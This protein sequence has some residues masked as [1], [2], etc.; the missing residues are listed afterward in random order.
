M[1]SFITSLYK[2]GDYLVK[3]C[4]RT[5]K[6][7][8][9]LKRLGC[10]AEFVIIANEP[11]KKERV[12][13]DRLAKNS[14]FHIYEVQRETLYASWNRG[15]NL[16]RGNVLGFW[17]VDDSRSAASIIEAKKIFSEPV[18]LVYF[19][20]SII[21][22]F[23]IFGF[24]LPVKFRKIKPPEFEPREFSRSMLCGPFFMFTK[25]FYNQVGPFDEQ[26]KV[27]ADFDWCIRAAKASGKFVLA[28]SLGGVFRVDGAGLSAG[29][30]NIRTMEN[31]VIYT[32]HKIFDKLIK[33]DG[34]FGEEYM[35]DKIFGNNKTIDYK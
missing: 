21:W 5:Q 2:S 30:N 28:D 19:P 18:D 35:A 9:R 11:D 16:A 31:N 10:D 15:V 32:R 8:N 1:I 14:N 24:N 12:W 34:K 26:F 4:K 20:F 3:Y 29:R 33:T 22:F 23:K 7:S 25:N 27:C 13:L 6:V 17:N